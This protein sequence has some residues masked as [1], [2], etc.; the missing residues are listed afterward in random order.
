MVTVSRLGLFNESISKNRK[1]FKPVFILYFTVLCTKH[2]LVNTRNIVTHHV[3]LAQVITLNVSCVLFLCSSYHMHSNIVPIDKKLRFYSFWWEVH[4]TLTINVWHLPLD[5]I[6]KLVKT[7]KMWGN[8]KVAQDVWCF[9]LK[10][11]NLSSSKF[12]YRK[13]NNF[14]FLLNPWWPSD[15]GT[16]LFEYF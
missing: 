16:A 14:K 5:H 8:N 3:I 4:K 12:E 9:I 11:W 15:F 6:S 2:Q 1:C 13:L 7:L 10:P